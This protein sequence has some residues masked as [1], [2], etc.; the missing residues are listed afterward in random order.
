MCLDP[1]SQSHIIEYMADRVFFCRILVEVI[2]NIAIVLSFFHSSYTYYNG[3]N[4]GCSFIRALLSA[5]ALILLILEIFQLKSQDITYLTD[6]WNLTD[7]GLICTLIA[8]TVLIG[9]RCAG[10]GSES[11]L[12][13]ERYIFSFTA[14][15]ATIGLVLALRYAFL[16]FAHNKSFDGHFIHVGLVR[17][18][19]FAI[20]TVDEFIS[21]TQHRRN[22]F[23]IFIN[24]KIRPYL[25]PTNTFF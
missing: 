20:V 3:S 2:T 12:D 1:I 16:P 22:D 25:L 15:F 8:L 23:I 14:F 4:E 21:L 17:F 18:S 7:W 13:K 10:D 24:L 19:V 5:C 6:I 11:L 9:N